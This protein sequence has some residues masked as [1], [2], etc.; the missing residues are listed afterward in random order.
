MKKSRQRLAKDRSET[1]AMLLKERAGSDPND[2]PKTA[3]ARQMLDDL[4]ER[5]RLLADARLL[6]FRKTADSSVSHER[7]SSPSPSRTVACERDAAD[8]RQLVEREM[9]DALLERERQRSDVA[10]GKERSEHDKHRVDLEV[11]RQSTNEQLSSERDG[12][13][14]ATSVLGATQ[15]ALAHA[16]RDQLRQDEVLGF[17]AHD[18]RSP[19]CIISISAECIAETTLDSGIRLSALRTSRA[20]ARMDRLLTDLLDTV[21]IH[22]GSLSVHRMQHDVGALVTEVFD[23]YAPLF[24]ARGIAFCID[25]K[26]EAIVAHFDHDRIVQVLSNLL[27]NAM[28]FTPHGGHV[29]LQV[30]REPQQVQFALTD[31]GPG[32]HP[33]AV[34]LVFKRFWQIDN[35]TRR[36]LGLGLH[37]AEEIVKAHGGRIWVETVF[38]NGSTFKFILPCSAAHH[39]DAMGTPGP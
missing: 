33:S 28:K 26:S 23:T 27:G 24:A 18:L 13:Y 10:V 12:A 21:R 25:M 30:K 6:K 38:G 1:D 20:V 8:Q 35:A 29:T 11:L 37:I 15:I 19:L 31:D 2:V 7:S 16:Q 22:A 17:V 5:D 14:M 32:I 9:S 34:P 3:E 39:N 36:G 4:I